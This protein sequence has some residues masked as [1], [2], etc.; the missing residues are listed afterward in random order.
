MAIILR[1]DGTARA[2]R[3]RC[4]ICS[5]QR[6]FAALSAGFLDAKGKQ[7]FACNDHFTN[8]SLLILGW[9]DFIAGQR[10]LLRNTYETKAYG[11]SLY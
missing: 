6:S 10:D 2:K 8:F 11:S 1:P 4:V 7:R 9:A 5:R 3:A